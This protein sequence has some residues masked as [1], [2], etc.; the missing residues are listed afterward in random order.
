MK[1]PR[2]AC[3]LVALLGIGG[4]VLAAPA[5]AAD[6]PELVGACDTPGNAYGVAVAGSY[7][8]VTNRYYGLRVIDVSNPAAPVE[9]GFVYT[10]DAASGVA[11]AGSYAYVADRGA[12]LLVIDVSDPAAPSWVG[13]VDTPGDAYGVAVAGS[14]A[15]VAD[16]IAGLEILLSCIFQDGFE[17]GDTSRWSAMVP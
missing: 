3:R 2:P 12:G 7:A 16:G 14:Y 11:V 5:L 1:S 4:G 6:C 8:Y 15:Y 9:V 10:R 13:I 17:S